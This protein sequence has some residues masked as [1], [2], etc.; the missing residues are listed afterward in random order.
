MWMRSSAIIVATAVLTGSRSD[1]SQ[2]L[3]RDHISKIL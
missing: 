1:K 3:H 2:V